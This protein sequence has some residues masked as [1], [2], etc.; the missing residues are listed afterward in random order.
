MNLQP[1]YNPLM[2][3]VGEFYLIRNGNSGSATSAQCLIFF[4]HPGSYHRKQVLGKVHYTAWVD[5]FNIGY[6]DRR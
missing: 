4:P 1:E 5:R 2:F 6:F 3:S